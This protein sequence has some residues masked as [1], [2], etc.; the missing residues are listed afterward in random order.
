MTA[1]PTNMDTQV[2]P[3]NSNNANPPTTLENKT[4]LDNS[5]SSSTIASDPLAPRADRN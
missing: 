4:T 2:S 1:Q 5:D 3:N